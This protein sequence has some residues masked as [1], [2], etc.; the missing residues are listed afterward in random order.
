MKLRKVHKNAGARGY[1]YRLYKMQRNTRLC[2][3]RRICQGKEELHRGRI[4]KM[5]WKICK[6]KFYKSK[7]EWSCRREI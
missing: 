1:D 3:E 2:A 6:R 7:E 5:F 4:L